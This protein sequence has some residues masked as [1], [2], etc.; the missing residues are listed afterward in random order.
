M[1]LPGS[2]KTT[3]AEKISK[4]LKAD[5]LN[6]DNIRSKFNDYDFTYTGIIRQ[7]RRMKKLSIKSKKK[8]VVADF[9]CPKK[10][11]IK[12]FMP[13]FIIWMDT[14]KKGRFDNMNKM[15]RPPE[16]YNLRFKRKNIKINLKTSLNKIRSFLK[17]K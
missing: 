4:K 1:G 13:D 12:I 3:L 8:F 2:G 15:F 10:K 14:I 17:N 16:R 9:V 6:A 7:V 11:Q 5:W